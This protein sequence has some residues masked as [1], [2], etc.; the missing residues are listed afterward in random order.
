MN[1]VFHEKISKWNERINSSI[2]KQKGT[3]HVIYISDIC[4]LTI[5]NKHNLR[6]HSQWHASLNK[7]DIPYLTA[8]HL[9]YVSTGDVGLYGD[10]LRAGSFRIESRWGKVFFTL[11]VCP[12]GHQAFYTMGTGYFPV[13]KRPGPGVN[14]S[15]TTSAEIKERIENSCTPNLGFHG[16]V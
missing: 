16:L 8:E 1:I 7:T 2:R 15:P 13:V 9:I 3:N 6:V 4:I 11:P 12:C 14:H 10:L 5:W